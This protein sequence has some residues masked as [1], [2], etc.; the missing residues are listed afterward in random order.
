MTAT[1]TPTQPIVSRVR[2]A[3]RRGELTL[4]PLPAVATR[5]LEMLQD[6]DHLELRKLQA[7]IQSDG[8]MAASI[9]R[10]ANSAAF[11]G[12]QEISDLDRAI[13]RLGLQQVA[14]VVVAL[15]AKSRFKSSDANQAKLLQALWDHALVTALAAKRLTALHG[16]ETENAFLAGLLH[17]V[18][19][20]LV[21]KFADD[22]DGSTPDKT[23]VTPFVMDELMTA[24]HAEMGY[25]TLKSWKIPEVIAR[26]ALLH[27]HPEPAAEDHLLIRVQAA[28]MIS[29]KMGAHPQPQP[30]L[31]L[32]EV[33]SIERLNLTDLE[34]AVLQ[35]DLE[36]D[37]QRAR[38]LL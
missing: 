32:M 9:L 19:K 14:S 28:N 34:L 25:E 35:T 37:F 21:L 2:D 20:L 22:C 27:H 7:T 23:P 26:V 30:D 13:S 18:G 5:V 6:E 31:N 11:G 12:L 17:D 36:D 29:R 3:V 38:E 10:M 15:T 4:P 1:E 33:Q 16:G 24:V 8:A